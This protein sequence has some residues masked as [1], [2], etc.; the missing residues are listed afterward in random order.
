VGCHN[1]LSSSFRSLDIQSRWSQSRGDGR[2]A[3]SW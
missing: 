1:S 2:T 3:P